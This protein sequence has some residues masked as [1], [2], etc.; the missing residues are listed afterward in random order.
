MFNYQEHFCVI[1]WRKITS[2]MAQGNISFWVV[3]LIIF[4]SFFFFFFFHKL[5]VLWYLIEIASVNNCRTG[6]DPE[7]DLNFF[8]LPTWKGSDIWHLVRVALIWSI[9]R[10]SSGLL[11]EASF[12][13]LLLTGLH[14]EHFPK[15]PCWPQKG[16]SLNQFNGCVNTYSPQIF[17]KP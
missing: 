4:V 6:R 5:G 3:P 2:K 15:D 8:S 17:F 13:L 9:L 1:C 14:L 7:V 16:T 11:Q 10:S 12:I